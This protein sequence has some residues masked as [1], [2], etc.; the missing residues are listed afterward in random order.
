[1][2]GGK[3]EGGDRRET[4]LAATRGARALDDVNQ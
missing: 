2:S 4:K 1:M 3:C